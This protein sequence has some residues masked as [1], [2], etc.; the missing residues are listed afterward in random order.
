MSTSTII[1]NPQE[2]YECSLLVPHEVIRDGLAKMV[3]I[4]ESREELTTDE[5]KKFQTWYSSYFVVFVHEHHSTE[6]EIYFPWIATKAQL[7]EK[8]TADHKTLL[9][10]MEEI[11]SVENL[12][13]LQQKVRQLHDLMKEHL[14]EEEEVISP[15]LKEHF[16]EKEEKAIIQ[17]ILPK[18]GLTGARVGLPWI[19]SC[20]ETWATDEYRMKF[21]QELPAFPIRLLYN[22]LWVSDYKKN[23][24]KALSS[25]ASTPVSGD[26]QS[27]LTQAA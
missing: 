11:K 7:P 20:M 16:S 8:I 2:W 18:L 27:V 3:S 17:K 14:A 10:L 25:L 6:E 5:M 13:I 15:I 23:N 19:L 21:Y 4:L 26:K 24:V 22:C 1:K 9:K 12:K